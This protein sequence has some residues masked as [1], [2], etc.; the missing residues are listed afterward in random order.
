M[1]KLVDIVIPIYNRAHCI[2]NLIEEL[3]NQTMQDFCAVFVDDGSTDDSYAVLQEALKEEPFAYKL[4]QQENGGAAAARNTAL[5]ATTGKWVAFVDSDDRMKPHYLEYMVRAVTE[6]DADLGVCHFQEIS[7]EKNTKICD[8]EQFAYTVISPVECMRM[9]CTEWLGV[10]CLL[11]SGELVR[12]RNL[13]FDEA[14]NYC[15]DAP[16]IADVIEAS[17][18]VAYV[19]QQ[20]YLYY[21]YQGSLSR[22]PKVSKFISG[23]NAFRRM[24]ADIA[25]R[26]SDAARV[27]DEMGSARYYIAVCRKA[28]VQMSYRDFMEL[29]DIVD[30]RQYRGKVHNLSRSQRMASQVLLLS[31]TL[32][33]YTIRLLFRD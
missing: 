4:I 1:H 31:K 18:K 29:V 26:D 3:R 28:A 10:Y 19:N 24:E 12:S 16:Y 13:Y 5:R 9:Y 11:I 6:A 2:S 33:Y 7:E 22:S 20:L 23:I 21:T 14:C 25:R 15:E 8:D 17:T 32:F 27:F 30:F